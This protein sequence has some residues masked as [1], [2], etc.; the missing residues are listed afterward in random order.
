MANL[1]DWKDGEKLTGIDY[2]YERETITDKA[3]QLDEEATRKD[4]DVFVLSR[5]APENVYVDTVWMNPNQFNL[6]RNFTGSVVNV[7]TSANVFTT[8]VFTKGIETFVVANA[9]TYGY[10]LDF[11]LG[12]P[13]D[14]IVQTDVSVSAFKQQ[15]ERKD[16]QYNVTTTVSGDFYKQSI[17]RF[18]LDYNVTAN[19]IPISYKQH[20]ERLDLDYNVTVNTTPVSYKQQQTRLDLDYNVTTTVSGDFYKQQQEREELNYNV[21]TT[22][23]GDFYKQ[24]YEKISVVKNVNTNVTVVSFKNVQAREHIEFSSTASVS[25]D[26]F[27]QQQEKFDIEYNVTANAFRDGYKQQQEETFLSYDVTISYNA[28]AYKEQIEKTSVSYD[29][30]TTSSGTGSKVSQVDKDVDYDVTTISSGTGFKSFDIF[31]SS[32]IE[33][34]SNFT[35][36]GTSQSVTVNPGF[37]YLFT[38][39]EDTTFQFNAPLIINVGATY[40]QFSQALYDIG[41]NTTL[42]TQTLPRTINVTGTVYVNFVYEEVPSITVY[43]KSTS[44][45]E[46]QFGPVDITF[47]TIQSGAEIETSTESVEQQYVQSHNFFDFPGNELKIVLDNPT[48]TFNAFQYTW[49]SIKVYDD[50]NNLEQTYTNTGSTTPEFTFEPNA[51]P[52]YSNAMYVEVEYDVVELYTVK[53]RLQGL[54]SLYVTSDVDSTLQ[55]PDFTGTLSGNGASQ[56]I[57]SFPPTSRYTLLFQRSFEIY[58]TTYS[59]SDLRVG[60]NS[61]LSNVHINYSTVGGI[62]YVGVLKTETQAIDFDEFANLVPPYSET[63]ITIYFSSGGI[64]PQ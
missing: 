12:R 3:T 2:T 50:F 63:E 10:K 61:I 45:P 52:T 33:F 8:T 14:Y 54:P 24:D 59:F 32:N 11:I 30:A 29:V 53:L 18:D 47:V 28:I 17:E 27:K 4:S 25:I 58:G 36:D 39:E 22:V 56:T 51:V 9:N 20:Q 5:Y 41:P 62:E 38:Q 26:A 1:K 35:F 37:S 16:I 19:T 40:Y 55:N 44:I 13:V 48:Y 46:T 57:G 49:K 42:S 34:T 60:S 7:E 15:Q 23:S 43:S 21:T 31:A 64:Q 6:N